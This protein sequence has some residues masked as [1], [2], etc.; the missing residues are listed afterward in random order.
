M[1]S[2]DRDHGN[3]NDNSDVPPVASENISGA[4]I[5]SSPDTPA[6]PEG[7]DNGTAV[8]GVDT[9]PIA[10]KDEDRSRS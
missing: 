5:G 10:G 4:A 9:S 3:D 2:H 6:S 1:P 8:V 7:S